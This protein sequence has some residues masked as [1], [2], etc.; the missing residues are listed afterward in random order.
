M[1]D[2]AMHPGKSQVIMSLLTKSRHGF[3]AQLFIVDALEKQGVPLPAFND[4]LTNET[5]VRRALDSYPQAAALIERQAE[6]VAA[7][8][9]DA[10]I[11]ALG[12]GHPMSPR[13]WHGVAVEIRD[14][15][16]SAA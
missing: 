1:F 10:V 14:A 8:G 6:G 11:N 16:R 5:V 2:T 9:V 15:L 3:M 4:G 13:S 7:A 12:E